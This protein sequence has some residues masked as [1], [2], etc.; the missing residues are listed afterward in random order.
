MRGCSEN[1]PSGLGQL[2]DCGMDPSRLPALTVTDMQCRDQEA[3]RTLILQGLAEYWEVV[4]P[5]LNPDLVDIRKSYADGRTVVA[6]SDELIV[7]T[8]TVVPR[9]PEVAEIVRMS[10]RRDYRRSGVG[11]LVVEE[12]VS[13]ARVWGASRVILETTAHWQDVTAFYQSNGFSSP[14]VRAARTDST[15]GCNSISERHLSGVRPLR[16]PRDPAAV[17]PAMLLA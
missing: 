7:A 11:S 2:H 10:V 6:R 16:S 12:L 15:P 9:E 14:I 8:G 1:S 5:D 13:T 3:V 17:R 4:N